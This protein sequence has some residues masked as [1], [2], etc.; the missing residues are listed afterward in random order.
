[1][2]EVVIEAPTPVRCVFDGA[3]MDQVVSNLLSNAIKY[4]AGRPIRLAVLR[5]GAS[6]RLEVEDHGIGIAAE[7]QER[8]FGRFE[9]AVSGRE[10]PGLGLGL[11]IVRRLVEAHGGT[12]RLR[13][14]PREGATF[15][16]ELPAD[17]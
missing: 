4:G 12:I 6:V 13:S 11:W 17:P 10:Y 8:I 3:R 16:V 9:R 5:C 7:L 1:V 15:M 2:P 14:A